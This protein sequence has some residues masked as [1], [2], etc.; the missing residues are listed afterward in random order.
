MLTAP[1]PD[2]NYELCPS[3]TH[4]AR[5]YKII[6]LGTHDGEWQGQPKTTALVRLYWELPNEIKEYEKDGQKVSAPF[7]ISREFTFSMGEKAN[8]RKI[9]EGMIGT[10]LGD[11]E[12]FAFDIEQL[13]GMPCLVTIVHEVGQSSGKKFAKLTTTAPMMRGMEAPAQVN[14]SEVL[15]VNDLSEEAIGKLPD[16]LQD[17]M[18]DSHEYKR[19]V[20]TIITPNTAPQETPSEYPELPADAV[21][22]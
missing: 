16:W 12:A 7:A 14:E 9:V 1:K 5:L 20:G 10:T 15:D 17:K 13:L 8:L 11:D 22:F 19:K 2:T 18:R 6:N 3:G 4:I 21:P